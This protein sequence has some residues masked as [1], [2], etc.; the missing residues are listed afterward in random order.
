MVMTSIVSESDMRVAASARF[1][2]SRFTTR[3]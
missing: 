3:S 2:R 1:V